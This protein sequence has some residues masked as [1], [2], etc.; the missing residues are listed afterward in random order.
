[1]GGEEDEVASPELLRAWVEEVQLQREYEQQQQQHDVWR[2]GGGSRTSVRGGG[3]KE[4][5]LKDV[6]HWACVEEPLEMSKILISWG[7]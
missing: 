4:V 1:V 3:V 5:I 6:G 7:S 2:K